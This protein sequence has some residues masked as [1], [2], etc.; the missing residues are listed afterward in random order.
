MSTSSIYDKV[1]LQVD[2]LAANSFNLSHMLDSDPGGL[3]RELR[4]IEETV[5]LLLT[6]LDSIRRSMDQTAERNKSALDE[7][8]YRLENNI[9]SQ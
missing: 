6:N 1:Q 5:R 9:L 2:S 7:L 8:R 4:E 3:D